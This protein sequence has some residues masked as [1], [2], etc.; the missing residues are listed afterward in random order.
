M[1]CSEMMCLPCRQ[2]KKLQ[3]KEKISEIVHRFLLKKSLLWPATN[4]PASIVIPNAGFSGP[5]ITL[6]DSRSIGNLSLS[7]N[8]TFHAAD[9]LIINEGGQVN[10]TLEVSG[11]L[12]N[13]GELRLRRCLVS[14][15]LFNEGAITQ[16]G[17]VYHQHH[18]RA[19]V[20]DVSRLS[21]HR[22]QRQEVLP[23]A[24]ARCA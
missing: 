17:S 20:P 22:Q 13:R 24:G 2:R 19:A 16:G 23:G 9:S 15:S 1:P 6:N 4:G 14:G 3:I 21:V 18:R 5:T 8:A 7:S 12:L 11:T 10:G